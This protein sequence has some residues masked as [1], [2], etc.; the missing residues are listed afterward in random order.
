MV[1]GL[2]VEVPECLHHFGPHALHTPVVQACLGVRADLRLSA[3]ALRKVTQSHHPAE[4]RVEILLVAFEAQKPRIMVDSCRQ[5][6]HLIVRNANLS[7]HESGSLLDTVA[8]AHG[9]APQPVEIPADHRHRI[10]IV[11]QECLRRQLLEIAGDVAKD[12]G[13]AEKAKDSSGTESVANGLI[14]TVT[15]RNLDAESIRLQPTDLECHDDVIRAK[16]RLPLL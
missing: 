9:S 1:A 8:Q 15:A 5:E 16:Q 12:W 2:R 11:E 14:D 3:V 6:L 7:R 13:R 10:D 4:F